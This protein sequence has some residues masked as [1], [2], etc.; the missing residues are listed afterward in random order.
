MDEL[1]FR[2]QFIL[3]PRIPKEFDHWKKQEID[4]DFFLAVHP[5]LN[6]DYAFEN[7][8][9]LF[10]LGFIMDPY[11]PEYSNKEVLN[12][13]MKGRKTFEKSLP[14]FTWF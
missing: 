11:N 3:G 6:M 12:Q 4:K 9:S 13:L 1:L 5:D 10:L 14:V 2:R 8:I 7:G